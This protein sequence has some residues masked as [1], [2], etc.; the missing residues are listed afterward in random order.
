M[1]VHVYPRRQAEWLLELGAGLDVEV[2]L[3]SVGV[4]V[5]LSELYDWGRLEKD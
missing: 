2:T 1:R 4:S 3:R 5:Q